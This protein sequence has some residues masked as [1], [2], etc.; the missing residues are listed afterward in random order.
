MYF[1]DSGIVIDVN[2]VQSLKISLAKKLIPSGIFIVVN[3]VQP[4]N[5]LVLKPATEA[6]IS[7]LVK[8]VQS[9][10]DDDSIDFKLRRGGVS[11]LSH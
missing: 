10:K 9:W 8:D 4:R 3:D 6:G 11:L 5:E 1:I 7:R 2:D